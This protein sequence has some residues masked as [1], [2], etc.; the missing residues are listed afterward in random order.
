[1]SG[2]VCYF[3]TQLVNGLQ[4]KTAAFSGILTQLFWGIMNVMVFTAFYQY[5]SITSINLQELVTYV[6]LNQAFLILIYMRIKDNDLMESIKNGTVAYELCRPYDL[7]SWWYIKL[8]TQK[9]AAVLLR[10]IP[11]IVFSI[12]LPYGYSLSAPNSIINFI[13]FCITLILGSLVL[14]AILMIILSISFF[15]C[16]DKGIS[17]IIFIVSDVLAGAIL[18]LPLLPKIIQNISEYLPFR[19]VGDLPFRIYSGNVDIIYALKS[20]ILQIIW[21]F[22]LVIIGR[23]IM[24]KALKNI[25]IQGG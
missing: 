7:Y 2:Y 11:V 9:Y 13:L 17:D 21:I 1:M 16:Q 3:K 15:T 6:W 20:L 25:C 19:L 8:L 5:S 24:R 18:P 4:Y 14:V 22:I 23:L 10:F 12:I